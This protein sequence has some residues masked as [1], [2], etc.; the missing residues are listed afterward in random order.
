ML[1]INTWIGKLDYKRR[2]SSQAETRKVRHFTLQGSTSSRHVNLN[3]DIPLPG[4]L[5]DKKQR[6]FFLDRIPGEGYVENG[7][8]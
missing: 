2:V 4:S 5:R 6:D 7:F 8:K 1:P 3:V